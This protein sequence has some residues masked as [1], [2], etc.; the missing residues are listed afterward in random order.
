MYRIVK[1]LTR[2]K[3]VVKKHV[4]GGF[5][6][7]IIKEG[8]RAKEGLVCPTF[9]IRLVKTKQFSQYDTHIHLCVVCESCKQSYVNTE[10]TVL[11]H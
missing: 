3:L 1:K 5:I 11:Y 8:V 4:Y 7:V 9:E 10:H 6:K 2:F